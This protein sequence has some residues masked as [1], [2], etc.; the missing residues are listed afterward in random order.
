[1]EKKRYTAA[2]MRKMAD[3]ALME[4]EYQ[5]CDC[6]AVYRDMYGEG[7]VFSPSSVRDMLYQAA[8]TEEWLQKEY[9]AIMKNIEEWPNH[10]DETVFAHQLLW[11]L[12]RV[13]GAEI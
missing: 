6:S 4:P 9:K 11:M 10:G 3:A 7:K 8:D 12:E 13:C 5:D 1:M 2:E